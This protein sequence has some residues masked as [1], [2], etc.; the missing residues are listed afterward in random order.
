MEKQEPRKFINISKLLDGIEEENMIWAIVENV[1]ERNDI[2][3]IGGR[4]G[5]S[6]RYYDD[7]NPTL[8]DIGEVDE[9]V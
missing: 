2:P 1:L 7:E 4:K 6:I 9:T 3:P 8:E 5:L